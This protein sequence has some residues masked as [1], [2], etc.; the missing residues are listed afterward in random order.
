MGKGRVG[1][2]CVTCG[3]W[4]LPPQ[5]CADSVGSSVSPPPT[6]PRGHLLR[7]TEDLCPRTESDLNV[8]DCVCCRKLFLII[9]YTELPRGAWCP[10]EPQ[11]H[12]DSVQRAPR[13]WVFRGGQ[14]P[15][16]G[17]GG[18]RDCCWFLLSSRRK[19]ATR[20]VCYR[21]LRG[22]HVTVELGFSIHPP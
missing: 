16:G 19:W 6:N 10:L 14:G 9:A 8:C 1:L 2:S 3:G 20:V 7:R 22:A 12:S 17:A 4:L 11:L 21:S 15:R 18:P 13:L 5:E